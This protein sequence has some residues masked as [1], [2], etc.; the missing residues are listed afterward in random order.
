MDR[1]LGDPGVAGVLCQIGDIAVH[2]TVDFDAF[3]NLVLVGFQSAVHVMQ[4]DACD[5]S[6]GSI[7]QFGRKVLGHFVVLSVLLPARHDIPSFYGYHPVHLRQFLRGILKVGIHG[8][9]DSAAGGFKAVE[10]GCRLAVVPSERD[11]PYIAVLPGYFRD[12]LP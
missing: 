1:F 12:H 8:E 2:L 9:D 4:P 11:P 3:D 10:Q 5:P 7:V 6:R